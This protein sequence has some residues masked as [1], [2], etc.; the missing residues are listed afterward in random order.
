MTL[1]ID[2]L[3]LTCVKI[4]QEAV[5]PIA[6]TRAGTDPASATSA[7]VIPLPELDAFKATTLSGL[8]KALDT[9]AAFEPKHDY[10]GTDEG[11]KWYE[12]ARNDAFNK[13]LYPAGAD[14][15]PEALTPENAAQRQAWLESMATPGNPWEKSTFAHKDYPGM[16][17]TPAD[18]LGNYSKDIAA[19][20]FDPEAQ[21]K[22]LEAARQKAMPFSQ[23]AKKAIGG[24]PL[25]E[26][27][28]KAEAEG[29]AAAV[30]SLQDNVNAAEK[31][32]P[33]GVTDWLT[34]NWQTLLVPGGLLLA[35]F[36]DNPVFTMVGLAAAGYG[37]YNLY[38]R[39]QYLNSAPGSKVVQMA[40][41]DAAKGK[42]RTPERMAQLKAMGDSAMAA[43]EDGLMMLKIGYT[44]SLLKD[45]AYEAG[46]TA[47]SALNQGQAASK[48][49]LDAFK[50]KGVLPNADR[51]TAEDAAAATAAANLP[52]TK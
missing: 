9:G 49:M 28:Q 8:G 48:T 44:R 35:A 37:G 42:I 26:T 5:D 2:S 6:R 13:R 41:E 36:S 12:Q 43:Y 38:G 46:T 52:V 15:K 21:N 39:Y 1:P 10:L 50:S 31:S 45:K 3:Y 25:H 29:T 14:G 18:M 16:Q 4:A 40:A 32:N 17:F 11:K 47:Y 27:I 51:R 7:P 24:D 22:L 34:N 20:K 33:A 23:I 19:A 30:K